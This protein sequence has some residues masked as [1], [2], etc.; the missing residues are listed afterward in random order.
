MG[1]GVRR[2]N[3]E[4]RGRV[5]GLLGRATAQQH[6]YPISSHFFLFF[7]PQA[8]GET[9][10]LTSPH[11]HVFLYQSC[12][13][14]TPLRSQSSWFAG[15]PFSAR[16]S[17]SASCPVPTVCPYRP[18]RM[19]H[20]SLRCNSGTTR[21]L[22]ILSAPHIIKIKIHPSCEMEDFVETHVCKL[23]VI[24]RSRV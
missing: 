11:L 23:C 22:A 18:G 2:H 3:N 9:C 14:L 7:S 16:G 17:D 21:N 19:S 10:S 5:E 6:V 13:N 24:L 4:N 8:D 12:V 20:N 15:V 1:P